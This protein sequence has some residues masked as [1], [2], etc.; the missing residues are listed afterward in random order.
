MQDVRFKEKAQKLSWKEFGSPVAELFT[1]VQRS[2]R[3]CQDNSV[4]G[5]K[6]IMDSPHKLKALVSA[7]KIYCPQPQ[8]AHLQCHS[9][10]L[11]FAIPQSIHE[12]L[13][14]LHAD[15]DGWDGQLGC[16]V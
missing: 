3:E 9:E 4:A 5:V 13:S 1:L 2:D 15:T 6:P 8:N 16:G 12:L 10:R 14:P 11:C 7:W